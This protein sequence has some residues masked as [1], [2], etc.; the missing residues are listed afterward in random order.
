MS[1][2][3]LDALLSCDKLILIVVRSFPLP[4]ANFSGQIRDLID[5]IV[6]RISDLQSQGVARRLMGAG[7]LFVND[8]RL[9]GTGITADRDRDN[10]D[11]TIREVGCMQYSSIAVFRC[12]RW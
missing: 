2:P 5:L 6:T 11:P 1:L 3:R 4:R 7:G 8:T 9:G 10:A 12:V